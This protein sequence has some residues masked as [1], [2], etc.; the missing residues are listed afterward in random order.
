AKLAYKRFEIDLK[1][2]PEWYAPKVNPASKVPA[3][4]HG[5]PDV[6]PDT[7][8]PASQK[9]TESAVLLDLLQILLQNPNYSP[10]PILRAKA[11]FFAD[12]VT[13]KLWDAYQPAIARGEDPE[14]VLG[15]IDIIQQLLPEEGYAVGKW[16]IADAAV[17]L[18]LARGEVVLKNDIGKYEEGKGK[19]V[20]TDPKYARFR[21]YLMDV[22]G[23][24]M[25]SRKLSIQ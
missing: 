4:T 25:L 24:D 23:R 5:G 11:R 21:K 18:F 3:L 22:E 14:A 9:L 15:A 6:A 7:P 2:K 17:T 16:S 20:E 12:T 1:N 8:S 19:A 13:T 10:D